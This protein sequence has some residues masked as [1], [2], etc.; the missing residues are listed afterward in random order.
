MYNE[1]VKKGWCR[2]MMIWCY[3][4]EIPSEVARLKE[5]NRKNEEYWNKRYCEQAEHIESLRNQLEFKTKECEILQNIDEERLGLKQTVELLELHSNYYEQGFNHM[6]ELNDKLEENDK[7]KEELWVYEN[8]TKNYSR[9]IQE[10]QQQ[11]K[12]LKEYQ[13][14]DTEQVNTLLEQIEN[15]EKESILKLIREMDIKVIKEILRLQE[16]NKRIKGTNEPLAKLYL[17]SI[18]G[19]KEEK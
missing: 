6:K 11:I 2:T 18:Y 5:Q 19:K 13:L 8:G 16:E 9:D 15:E 1:Y 7:L 12:K 10:L 17:N 4:H 14:M 3:Q